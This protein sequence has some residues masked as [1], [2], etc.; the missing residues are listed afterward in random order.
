MILRGFEGVLEEV[1]YHIYFFKNPSFDYNIVV[2]I[3]HDL[4]FFIRLAM[5]ELFFNDRDLQTTWLGQY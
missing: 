2:D 1:Q 4:T 5:S 3:T